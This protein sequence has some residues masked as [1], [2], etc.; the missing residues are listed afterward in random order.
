MIENRPKI[1]E[2]TEDLVSFTKA[3]FPQMFHKHPKNYLLAQIL[4]KQTS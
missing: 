3:H 1:G 4:A 2:L